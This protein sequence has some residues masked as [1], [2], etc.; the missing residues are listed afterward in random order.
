M[1]GLSDTSRFIGSFEDDLQVWLQEIFIAI[2]FLSR[3]DWSDP[4]ADP[5]LELWLP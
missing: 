3:S 1:I 5:K 2:T 4:G